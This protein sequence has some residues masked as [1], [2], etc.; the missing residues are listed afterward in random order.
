[1]AAAP[2]EDPERTRDHRNGEAK[3]QE[4]ATLLV[5]ITKLAPQAR[6]LRFEGILTSW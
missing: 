2:A 3:A 5:E 1:M 6:G 4:L